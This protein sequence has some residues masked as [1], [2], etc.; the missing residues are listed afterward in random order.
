MPRGPWPPSQ[1][2]KLGTP[3][4]SEQVLRLLHCLGER[5]ACMATPDDPAEEQ[6]SKLACSLDTMLPGHYAQ[7][8]T[9]TL[10]GLHTVYRPRA[11][12][13]APTTGLHD[14]QNLMNSLH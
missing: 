13:S 2:S 7:I 1:I 4:S 14:K 6:R 8:D 3:T 12:S 9:C 10:Q 5:P 11:P